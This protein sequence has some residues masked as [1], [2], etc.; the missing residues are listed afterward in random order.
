MAVDLT[1][2]HDNN[3]GAGDGMRWWEF[4]GRIWIACPNDHQA[5]I[6]HDIADDG[7]VTPSLQCYGC[8]FHKNVKLENWHP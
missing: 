8:N 3:Q 2:P 5:E 6:D 7:T 1:I 4:R